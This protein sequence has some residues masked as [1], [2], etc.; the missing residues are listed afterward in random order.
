MEIDVTTDNI[1]LSSSLS[2]KLPWGCHEPTISY[3]TANKCPKYG[4]RDTN[5]YRPFEYLYGV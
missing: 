1:T 4:A 3:A 2:T 5:W